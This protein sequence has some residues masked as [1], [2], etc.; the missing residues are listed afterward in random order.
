MLQESTR[1]KAANMKKQLSLG[2]KIIKR[3]GRSLTFGLALTLFLCSFAV[4]AFA[5]EP[6][7][8]TLSVSQSE[9]NPKD[10]F[11]LY[12]ALDGANNDLLA[13]TARLSYDKN[14]FET[15]SENSFEERDNWSDITYNAENQ[16][17]VLINKSGS[18][19]STELLQITMRVKENAAPGKTKITLQGITASNGKDIIE[20]AD[21][22]V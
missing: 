6:P 8:E 16:K 10:E 14:V 13:Y 15:V 20:I 12:V 1:R 18:I 2:S 7:K 3:I 11:V 9:L 5:A 22:T 4:N 17:F 21:G 19:D